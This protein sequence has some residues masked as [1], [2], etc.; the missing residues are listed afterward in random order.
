MILLILKLVKFVMLLFVISIGGESKAQFV[1]WQNNTVA[2]CDSTTSLRYLL[3]TGTN[4]LTGI[5]VITLKGVTW[6]RQFSDSV[7]YRSL[8]LSHAT[9]VPVMLTGSTSTG[10]IVSFLKTDLTIDW[11]KVNTPPTS[12]SGYGITDAYPLTGNPSGFIT[13]SNIYSAGFGLTKTGSDPTATLSVNTND[14]MTVNRAAD[15][16]AS[17]NA[18]MGAI[19][20][21]VSGKAAKTTTLTINGVPHDIS[22]NQSWTVGTLVSNDTNS[23]NGAVLANSV[24]IVGLTTTVAGKFNTPSGTTVQYIDGTGGLQ[25]SKTTLSQFT[26]N[27]GYGTE[28]FRD[29]TK[30]SA[31]TQGALNVKQGT[32][33]LTTAGSSGAATLIGNILN[34]PTYANSGGTVTT[35]SVTPANG[36]S[37]SV[38]NATTTPAISLTLGAITPSSVNGVVFSGTST[39]TLSVSGTSSISGTHSGTSSGTNTGDQTIPTTL[40]PSG[41]AGGD[42]SGSYPNPSVVQVT[43][44]TAGG[45]ATAG[46]VGEY[47]SSTVALASAVTLSTSTASN[48]TSISLTAGDWDVEGS[49][50]YV[51]TLATVSGKVS[52]INTTSATVPNDGTEV[53]SGLITTLITGND[54]TAL[55]RKR[56]NVTTTT[57]VYL[58][59]QCTFTVG[60]VKSYGVINARRVR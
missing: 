52:G 3:P 22:A 26:N 18:Q 9:S 4:C 15:S 37:G 50:A 57:T 54:G 12:L 32:I 58:V 25:T 56:I 53:P 1:S 40:P 20:T 10:K 16:I 23:L 51:S 49:V 44:T 24:A 11:S 55:P 59:A 39:P 34:V 27:L 31:A 45:N 46:K 35:V 60:G 14:M 8:D 47:I 28:A 2:L 48:V 7:I 5:N 41:S 36:V 42:V 38:S 13:T 33:T 29:S 19:S 6:W 17:I 43:G 30:I 21:A